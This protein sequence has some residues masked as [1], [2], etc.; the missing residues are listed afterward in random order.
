MPHM[1]VII[2]HGGCNTFT[3]AL[4]YGKPMIILP[5]SSD[6]FSIAYDAE[7]NHLGMTLDPNHLEQEQ[8]VNA[9]VQVLSQQRKSLEK[10]SRFSKERGPDFAAKKILG[11]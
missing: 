8:I 11:I 2:H 3:E 9:L 6:Q 4:F 5:F 10:W 7:K 1:D